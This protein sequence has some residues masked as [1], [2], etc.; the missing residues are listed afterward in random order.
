MKL[1]PL[2]RMGM[3]LA[4]LPAASMAQRAT[5]DH[6]AIYVKDL[7]ASADFYRLIIGLSPIPE[8]FRDGRHAWFDLGNGTALHIIQGAAE[9]REYYRNQHTCFRVASVEAFTKL[10]REHSIAWEDREG[11]PGKVTTRVDGV[12]QIWLRDPDGYWIEIN[13]AKGS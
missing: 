1:Y 9:T 3:L 12:R 13:D 11:V 2:V 8:P 6:T 7:S 4:L 5:L 10:L